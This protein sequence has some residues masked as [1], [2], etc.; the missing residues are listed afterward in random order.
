VRHIVQTSGGEASWA[1]GK[2]VAELEGTK[3]FA[4]LFCDTL[5]EHWDT[6]R[7]LIQ[8]SANVLGVPCPDAL[9]S[10]CRLLPPLWEPERRKKALA[11]LAI[12]AQA[13]VPCLVWIS[14]GRGLWEVFRDERLI[15]NTKQDPCSRTLKRRLA[16]AWQQ[17]HCDPANTVVYVGIGYHEYHRFDGTKERPGLRRL[18]ATQGWECRAPLC[19]PPY[20]TRQ[21]IADWVTEEGIERQELYRLGYP[22]ANCGGRCVKAGHSQWAAYLRDFPQEYAYDEAQEE[23]LRQ[24]LGKDVSILRNRRGGKSRP[25]TLR[26][27]RERTEAGHGCDLFEPGGDWGGCGCFTDVE[28]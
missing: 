17:E 1:T 19:D 14:E 15:G 4:L 9:L 12:E 21:E 2:L 11:V 3:D 27:F 28:G 18:M 10:Q 16:G 25:L 5:A 24:T 26:A 20:L 13:A 6:Y 7:F 22:H 23:A 8:G